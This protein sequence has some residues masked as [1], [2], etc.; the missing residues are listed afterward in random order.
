MEQVKLIW[1]VSWIFAGREFRISNYLLIT[2]QLLNYF[3][4]SKTGILKDNRE[5]ASWEDQMGHLWLKD[6]GRFLLG[7]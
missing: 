1:L 2:S 3:T 7:H 5:E 6:V 4:L